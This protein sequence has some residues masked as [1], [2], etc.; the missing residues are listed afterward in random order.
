[1]NFGTSGR[2]FADVIFGN[3]FYV[4][5]LCSSNF[6]WVDSERLDIIVLYLELKASNETNQAG[7]RDA[8]GGGEGVIHNAS[9]GV[10][11]Y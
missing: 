6:T 3:V 4:G 5:K 10:R 7:L 2:L 11:V 9:L 1:M 8:V